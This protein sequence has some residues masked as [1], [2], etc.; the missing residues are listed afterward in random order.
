MMLLY[1][2]LRNQQDV[3]NKSILEP[4][5]VILRLILL[6]YKPVD[7]KLMIINNGI[8]CVDPSFYQG[9]MR[10]Y[11]GVARDDLHNLYMPIMKCIEWYTRDSNVN[12]Y[13]YTHCIKGID[14]LIDTYDEGTII[15]HTLL[16]Y[17]TLLTS[18]LEK[19]EMINVSSTSPMIDSLKDIWKSHEIF[20]AYNL[21]K[22]I[23]ENENEET[24]QVY[25][26]SLENILDHKEK[27]LHEMIKRSAS[28]YN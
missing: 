8:Q 13:L 15:N 28:Q 17:K 27:I 25:V 7:T 9:L 23:N 4:I 24:K 21:V 20:I 16:H 2:Q 12:C 22:E 19:G 14:T 1:H 26:K 6:H 5:C 11:Y 18:Y 3:D 10:R